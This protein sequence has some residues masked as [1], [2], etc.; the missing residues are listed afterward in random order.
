MEMFDEQ[1][2]H[3]KDEQPCERFSNNMTDS[4]EKLAQSWLICFGFKYIR[5]V[6]LFDGSENAI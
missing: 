4:S 6:I 5:N 2:K 1:V 3:L